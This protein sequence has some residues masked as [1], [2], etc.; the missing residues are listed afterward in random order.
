MA[1][2]ESIKNTVT[3]DTSSIDSQLASRGTEHNENKPV[4]NLLRIRIWILESLLLA[5]LAW[6]WDF[7]ATWG[8]WAGQ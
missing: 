6:S 4:Y 1:S 2:Q 8:P 3:E 7:G 5:L